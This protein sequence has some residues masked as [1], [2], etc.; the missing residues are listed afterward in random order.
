MLLYLHLLTW[1]HLISDLSATPYLFIIN[2]QGLRPILIVKI[3]LALPIFIIDITVSCFNTCKHSHGCSEAMH[4]LALCQIIWFV[5]RLATDTVLFVIAFVVAPAQAL[6]MV[7]LLLSAIIDNIDHVTGI[8]L[9]SLYYLCRNCLCHSFVSSFVKKCQA[10]CTCNSYY[11]CNKDILSTILCTFLI[12][13]CTVCLIFTVTLLFI[14]LVDNGLQSAG[15]GGF[16]LSLIPPTAIFVIGLCVNSEFAINFYH[17][18]LTSS[19]TGRSATLSEADT[20]TDKD[21]K[22]NIQTN[23]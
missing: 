11:L 15:I 3:F 7:T 9:R 6:G 17:N 18:V 13:T 2:E 4:A 16:I 12:G 21:V 22:V 5:H 23:K 10:G 8:G 19:S 1:L 14:A 20:P